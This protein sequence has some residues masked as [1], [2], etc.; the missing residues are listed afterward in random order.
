MKKNK[1]EELNNY[2]VVDCVEYYLDFDISNIN[3]PKFHIRRYDNEPVKNERVICK[4]F[5]V[6]HGWKKEQLN[7]KPTDYLIG[8][9]LNIVFHKL[10]H[11]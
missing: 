5:L 11:Q 4:R 10:I 8:E 6:E 9:T 2:F 3:D 7:G 1:T